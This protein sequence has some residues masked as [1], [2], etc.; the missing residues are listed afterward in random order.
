LTVVAGPYI[1]SRVAVPLLDD[2]N[3][4]LPR[5]YR[6]RAFDDADREPIVAA[7]NAE[8]HPMETESAEE[9]RHWERTIED[10]QRLRF[11]ITDEA[12]KIAG[13]GAILVGMMARADG[14]QQVGLTVFKEHRRRGIGSAAVHSLEAEAKRRGVPRLFAGASASKPFA[15]EFARKRGYTE[16][17][18]RILSYRELATYDAGPWREALD[19]VS[20]QG[21]RFRTFSEIL[22][23][24]DDA[25]REGFWRELWEAEA[26]MWD[27]IPF[28]SPIPHWS[29]E[30]FHKM[31]VE[32]PQ[33][34]RDLSLVAYDGDIIVGYT[35]TGDREGQDGNTYMTG[36]ARTHRGRGIAMALKVDVLARAKARGLRAMTTVN[37]E[38][39]KAMR[40]VNIKLGYQ[41]TPDHVELEKRL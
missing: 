37:D 23:E 19:K 12:G 6:A 24:R 39:N 36:V 40:G 41:P 14:S 18:R 10:P 11:T 32:N 35:M 38:P 5:G 33:I 13:T 20:T 17:G 28:A 22:G 4:R 31:A 30:Q 29:F 1:V 21:I 3:A 34:M 9:W 27:D 25:G 16:I 15:L 26:P 2:L 8:A 7:G